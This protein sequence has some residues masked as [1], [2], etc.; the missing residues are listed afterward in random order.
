[1]RRRRGSRLITTGAAAVLLFAPAPLCAQLLDF[2]FVAIDMLG[3]VAS[4]SDTGY[5]VAFGTRFGFA[6]F[7]GSARLGIEID[8]WTAEHE[9]PAY[10]VR[11][12]MGGLAVW[13][14][15]GSAAIRPYI[16]AGAGIHSINT[17]PVDSIG[18]Q[19]PPQARRLQG[20]RVGASGFAGLTLRLSSTGAIWLVLEYRYTA[21]S[22]VPYQELRAGL[23]LAG[24]SR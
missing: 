15:F 18:G 9:A 13:R 20:V 19:L 16:G 5:G 24:S 4:V 8:W 14:D 21:I 23:R 11:D 6:D 22:D 10:E 3:G 17:S 1:M 2:R 12:I 7:F